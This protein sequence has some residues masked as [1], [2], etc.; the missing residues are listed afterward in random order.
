MGGL[1]LCGFHLNRNS[2]STDFYYTW[3]TPIENLKISKIPEYPPTQ[4]TA[5]LKKI[6]GKI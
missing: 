5:S 6:N 3:Q 4:L 2:L 1:S